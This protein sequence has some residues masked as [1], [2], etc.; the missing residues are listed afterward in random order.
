MKAFWQ[1][2]IELLDRRIARVMMRP[3]RNTRVRP[4]HV[5][6][7]TLVIGLA[8]CGLFAFGGSEHVVLASFLF[9]FAVFTDHM[10]G[11]LARMQNSVSRSGFF[12]DYIVGAINYAL[13]FASIG[14]GLWRES[15]D[16]WLLLLGSFAALSIPADLWLRMKMEMHWGKQTVLHPSRFGVELEDFIYLIFPWTWLWGV[17]GFFLGYSIGSLFYFFWSFATY[18]RHLHKHD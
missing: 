17:Q 5:T 13:L 15:G 7:G 2:R 14:Y 9:A 10:D 16:I 12:Y 8:A 4:N 6:T 3:L 11:E 1:R 18:Q